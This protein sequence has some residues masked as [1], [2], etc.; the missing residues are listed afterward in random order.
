LWEEFFNIPSKFSSL[1]PAVDFSRSG[2]WMCKTEA[3]ACRK[4]IA[5]TVSLASELDPAKQ[6][7]I[8]VVADL[9]ALF[10]HATA[11]LVSK[12]F[13]SY[14]QPE[15]REDLADEWSQIRPRGA[16]L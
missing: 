4:T 16:G 14:L 5:G 3:E 11:R 9:A 12:I 1:K 6:T 15:R 13:A 8:A 2:F 10:M 7:H